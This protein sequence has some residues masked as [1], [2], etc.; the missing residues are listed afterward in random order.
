MQTSDVIAALRQRH[1]HK[2]GR[3]ATVVEFD[4]IDLLAVSCWRSDNFV[5]H[6]YEVKV[7]RGDWLREL[8]S[9]RKADASMGRCDHW[10]LAAPAGIVKPGELP[11]NWGHIEI[12]ESGRARA[13]TKAPALR[14]PL[15][16]RLYFPGEN[17]P[18]MNRVLL[19][20]E[21][22]ALMARR[23]VYAEA[24]RDALG[25]LAED[26]GADDDDLVSALDQAA[27]ATGRW[28]SK[29]RK[30]Q[31]SRNAWQRKHRANQNAHI[32]HVKAGDLSSLG[33]PL[34]WCVQ[35]AIAEARNVA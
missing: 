15:D 12:S 9:P 26:T 27:L 22:F 23:F 14:A 4:R 1:A 29:Q 25:T 18:H 6:G 28:T 32:S 31:R 5:V 34:D 21:A 35:D 33:C 8:K 16:R 7:S 17:G 10:W 30:T 19:E 24:D 20:R 2:N 3:W 11:Q 13:K